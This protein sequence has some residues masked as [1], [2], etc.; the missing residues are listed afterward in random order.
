MAQEGTKELIILLH[1][2][3]QVW[4]LVAVVVL[5]VVIVAVMV[6]PYVAEVETLTL[7]FRGHQKETTSVYGVG[8][9]CVNTNVSYHSKYRSYK[10]DS[11]PSYCSTY[12]Y[13][14][15]YA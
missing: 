12:I 9:V 6:C 2:H 7:L 8:R 11:R 14:A 4:L 5:L 15:T 3:L 13:K 10:G 1:L